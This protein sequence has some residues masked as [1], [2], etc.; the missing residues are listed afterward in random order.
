MAIA[1][2]NGSWIYNGEEDLFQLMFGG[3]RELYSGDTDCC[4]GI[5]S[6]VLIEPT[7]SSGWNASSV[8]RPSLSRSRPIH[9]VST[10]Q[11]TVEPAVKT[12]GKMQPSKMK[13]AAV[14]AVLAA[15]A[16][17]ADTGS[18]DLSEVA[19]A[20]GLVLPPGASEALNALARLGPI[21]ITRHGVFQRDD[22][23][24]GV[25]GAIDLD[26]LAVGVAGGVEGGGEALFLL[27]LILE[28]YTP[29]P[30]LLTPNT[31][32]RI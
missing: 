6:G 28:P 2:S 13:R 8:R 25:G 32:R 22:Q 17:V 14:L 16:A 23:G 26:A 20:A 27:D 3:G 18:P 15:V 29:N 21:T 11:A 1:P 5:S 30:T 24:R 10:T 12:F 4:R 31:Y 9:L 7:D 19:R